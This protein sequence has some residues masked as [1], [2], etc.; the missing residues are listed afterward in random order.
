L[1]LFSGSIGEKLG[2]NFQIFDSTAAKTQN[3][4]PQDQQHLFSSTRGLDEYAI[5]DRTHRFLSRA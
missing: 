2:K 1:W 5:V 3:P 4:S